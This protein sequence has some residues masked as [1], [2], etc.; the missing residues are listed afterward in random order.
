MILDVVG[1]TALDTSL[2]ATRQS[3]LVEQK[4]LETMFLMA[5]LNL[6]VFSPGTLK[7]AAFVLMIV[8]NYFPFCV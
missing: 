1:P 6:T 2:P 3:C 5:F 7:L 4:V 8:P